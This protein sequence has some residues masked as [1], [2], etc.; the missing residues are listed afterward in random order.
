TQAGKAALPHGHPAAVGGIGHTGSTAANALAHTADV[1]I[2][3]GT[4]WQDFTTAS[5]T[6]FADPDVRFVNLNI[7]A[8]DAAKHAGV[9]LVADARAGLDALAAALRGWS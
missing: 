9:A 6:V 7:A 3:V 4:R 8:F 2:G 1:V 5:R